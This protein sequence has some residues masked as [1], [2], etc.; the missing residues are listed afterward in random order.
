MDI[1]SYIN[2]SREKCRLARNLFHTDQSDSTGAR[3]H[4][5]LLEI[6]VLYQTLRL[7]WS[8]VS[9]IRQLGT[10]VR[11]V[12][13]AHYFD[14]SFMFDGPFALI[15]AGLVT[16]FVLRGLFVKGRSKGYSYLAALLLFHLQYAAR[17]SQGKIEH[18]STFTGIAL[19]ALGLAAAA[20]PCVEEYRRKLAFGMTTFFIG[21]GYISS[22][23]CKL[24]ATGFNWVDGRHLW[25]WIDEKSID[26]LSRFG[27]FEL[28]SLQE[29]VTASQPAA[30][31]ILTTGLLVEL[32]GFTLWYRP[33]RP[34]IASLLIAMHLGITLTMH[35]DFTYFIYLL[36]II[37]FPW[38]KV[39]DWATSRMTEDG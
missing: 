18:G 29:L 3:W 22:A 7:C 32:F 2:F 36:I 12:G 24:V 28:N 37:G 21:L 26:M 33:T 5:K 23:I 16:F 14:V 20:H 25:L 17:F 38:Y 8:W 1:A 4:Y 6:M 19:L 9:E 10:V 30:T 27:A 35:I 15:T 31:L 13:L 11:P 39:F 34:Y